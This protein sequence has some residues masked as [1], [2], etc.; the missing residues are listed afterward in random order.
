MERRAP[1]RRAERPSR[2][3]RLSATIAVVV[4]MLLIAACGVYV[5]VGGGS[6]STGASAAAAPKVKDPERA[7]RSRVSF[8]CD[9]TTGIAAGTLINTVSR[10]A[11]HVV[12]ASIRSGDAAMATMR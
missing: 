3:N 2:F 7:E 11:E 9:P 8:T 5:L 4:L 12:T 6:D 1:T 10:P